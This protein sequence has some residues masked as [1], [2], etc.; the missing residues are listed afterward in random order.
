MSTVPML[1]YTDQPMIFYLKNGDLF[2]AN[3]FKSGHH[4]FTHFFLIKKINKIKNCITLML[5]R[6]CSLCC[7]QDVL[8]PLNECITIDMS[9]FCGFQP[10]SNVCIRECSHPPICMDDCVCGSFTIPSGER[11]VTIWRSNLPLTQFGFINIGLKKELEAPLKLR[12]Y[13]NP[14]EYKTYQ[15]A[16]QKSYEFFVTDYSVIKIIKSSIEANLQGTFD[17]KWRSV[18]R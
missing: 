13:S 9:C 10:I 1:D 18:I 4:E 16:D 17:I 8:V 14:L 12:I 15:L 3:S 7:D 2:Q 5:L 11:E 6:S